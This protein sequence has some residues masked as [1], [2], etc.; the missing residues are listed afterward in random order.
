MREAI[1]SGRLQAGAALRQEHIAKRFSA[2]R[3]P[4]R[5]ALR[6]LASEGFVID[7]PNKGAV[8]APFDAGELLEIYEMRVA[9]ET[10]ALRL[11]IPELTDTQIAQAEALQAQAEGAPSEEFGK[12]NKAF[13]DTLYQPCA[14][15]RLLAHIAS[16]NDLADRYLRVTVSRLDYAGRSHREHRALL[17]ACRKRNRARAGEILADHIEQAGAALYRILDRG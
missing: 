9:A 17:A 1:L 4:V 14:R 7:T 12:L 16:L 13:H 3:M 10:L 15:P 11:A 5:D 6:S 2:S 8:V